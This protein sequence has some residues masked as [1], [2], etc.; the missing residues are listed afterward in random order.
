MNA[1]TLLETFWKQDFR[2]DMEIVILP[3]TTKQAETNKKQ[4]IIAY[5]TLRDIIYKKNWSKKFKFT[6]NKLSKNLLYNFQS[7][8]IL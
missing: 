3:V 1:E 4:S 2:Y 7:F 5:I 8:Q 6:K